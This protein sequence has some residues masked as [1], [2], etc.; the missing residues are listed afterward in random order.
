MS[1]QFFIIG[2]DKDQF[3]D[4]SLFDDSQGS[5]DFEL[6]V[7]SSNEIGEVNQ[8]ATK[9][10]EQV[11]LVHRLRDVIVFRGFTR[12]ESPMTSNRFASRYAPIS[13]GFK[14]GDQ[15]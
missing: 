2:F 1:L 10:I 6:E 14:G 4:F 3:P 9:I 12:L 7:I 5:D 11:S 8:S 15:P 13:M